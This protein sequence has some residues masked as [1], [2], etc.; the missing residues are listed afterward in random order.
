MTCC[1][2]N[3]PLFSIDMKVPAKMGYIGMCD[4]KAMEWAYRLGE[5]VGDNL[6]FKFNNVE[7]DVKYEDGYNN[8][9]AH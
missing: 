8:K 1:L 3:I 6:K 5:M 2:I 4:P 7:W 9:G